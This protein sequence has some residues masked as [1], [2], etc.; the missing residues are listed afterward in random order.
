MIP[1]LK[2]SFEQ[3]KQTIARLRDELMKQIDPF[4]GL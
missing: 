1:V 3:D 2:E 4:L